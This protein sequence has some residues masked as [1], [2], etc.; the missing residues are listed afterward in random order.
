MTVKYDNGPR[1]KI[2][3]K[4][5]SIFEISTLDNLGYQISSKSD[6]FSFRSLFWAVFLVTKMSGQNLVPYSYSAHSK[7]VVYQ[8]SAKSDDI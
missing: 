7:T 2:P 4:N 8:I 3:R 6:N 5:G 1:K